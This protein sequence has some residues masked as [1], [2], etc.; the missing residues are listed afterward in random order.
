MGER[1]WCFFLGVCDV[2]LWVGVCSS[3]FSSVFLGFMMFFR[4]LCV[5]FHFSMVFLGCII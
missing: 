3:W 5:F 2:F 4:G 1:R